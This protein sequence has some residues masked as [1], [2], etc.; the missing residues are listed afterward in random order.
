M[1]VFSSLIN[2]ELHYLAATRL[3]LGHEMENKIN[4]AFSLTALTL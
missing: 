1:D 3:I 4:E 2:I